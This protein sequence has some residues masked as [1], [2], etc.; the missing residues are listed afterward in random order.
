ME[1][2]TTVEAAAAVKSADASATE[3]AASKVPS[4]EVS[5]TYEPSTTQARGEFMIASDSK[6]PVMERARAEVIWMTA[7]Y[8]I[9]VTPTTPFIMIPVMLITPSAVSISKG[10]IGAIAPRRI[11]TEAQSRVGAVAIR[12]R[13]ITS[14][15]PWRAGKTA[16]QAE[17]CNQQRAYRDNFHSFHVSNAPAGIGT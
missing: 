16:G 14:V 4:A 13:T 6:T 3:M 2:A 8:P 10:R 5:S 9:I 17:R 12:G 15:I 7:S 11:G 1:S